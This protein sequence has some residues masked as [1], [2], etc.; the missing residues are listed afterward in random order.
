M[1]DVDQQLALIRRGAD[2]IIQE[3]ELRARLE[4]GRPLRIKAGFDPTAPDLHLGH[5]VLINKLRHFQDLG[6]QV[7]FLIGDFTGMIGDPSGK[8]VT[9]PPLSRE[10]VLRNAETYKEQVFKILDPDKTEVAFNSSWMSELDAADMI[11][12]A[13]QYTVARMLERD[14]FDKRYRGNQ[15][16]AIHEF[17][18]PLVQGYDS[19]ALRADV[20]LGGTDQKFNLLMGRT[21]QKGHGQPPQICLTMPLLEGLDGVQKMSKSLG[22]YVGVTDAPGDM[23][24]KLLSLPDALTWRYYELLS[25][26]SNEELVRLKAE[27]GRL[28]SPQEAKK[29]FALEMV[30]RF[31]GEEAARTAPSSA[32]NL[33]AL[34]DIPENVP[35]VEVALGDEDEVHIVPLLRLAGLAQNGKAAKDVFGRG[36]VYVDGQQLTLERSFKRGESAVIQAGKKKIARVTI[37]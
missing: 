10:D 9:R 29:A 31:H 32:G 20:E 5:T 7:I 33:T 19:V 1:T 25:A 24:R 28:G 21:L 4:S 8:S 36:A 12:L 11:R 6:H 27:A 13:S 23:Y 16:I 14:D 17:L 30:T 15:P 18:Y 26:V 37:T 3:D 22:N 34:G 35:E 2:E